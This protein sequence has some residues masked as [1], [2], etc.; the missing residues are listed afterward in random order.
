MNAFSIGI[1]CSI[2]RGHVAGTTAPIHC[3][4]IRDRTASLHRE[5]NDSQSNATSRHHVM[6]AKGGRA[7]SCSSTMYCTILNRGTPSYTHS[8]SSTSSSAAAACSYQAYRS[9]TLTNMLSMLCTLNQ[10]GITIGGTLCFKCCTWYVLNIHMTTTGAVRI[11]YVYDLGHPKKRIKVL[12][13][14][15]Y[16]IRL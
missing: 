15:S 7:L 10:F 14:N 13:T 16:A 6:P 11:L 2:A 5:H 3:T 4:R 12:D 8:K 1:A 9:G